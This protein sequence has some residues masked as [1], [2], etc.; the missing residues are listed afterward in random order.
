MKA[1]PLT[2]HHT[3]APIIFHTCDCPASLL[4]CIITRLLNHSAKSYLHT[5]HMSH[6]TTPHTADTSHS[7]QSTHIAGVVRGMQALYNA[8][9]QAQAVHSFAAC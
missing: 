4:S 3:I 2:E 1:D 9:V 7:R 8:A 5:C 6:S